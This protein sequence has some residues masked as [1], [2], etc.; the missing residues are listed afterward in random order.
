M[1]LWVSDFVGDTMD[2]SAK[3]VGAYMLLLMALWRRN[4]KLPFDEKT[5]RTITRTGRDWPA[6]WMKIE[7]FF[8]I[9]D[10]ELTNERLAQELQN[11]ATKREVRSQLGALGGKAKA[12]KYNGHG[13]AKG[14]AKGKH[15]YS[16][17]K[18]DDKSSSVGLAEK[19]KM[20]V[21]RMKDK[22]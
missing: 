18:E 22:K 13:L 9:N 19:A 11:V 3:E 17:S 10:G 2:L 15:S 4:G 6:I 1:P 14:V 7:R 5:L 20:E 21:Q 8:C 16:Y 12:L